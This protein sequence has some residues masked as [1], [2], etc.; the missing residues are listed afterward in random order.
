MSHLVLN[1]RPSQPHAWGD[2]DPSS[3]VTIGGHTASQDFT[4]G[5]RSYRID[6]LQSGDS[7]D[8]V[9]EDVPGDATIN[10]KETLDAAFGGY[11]SFRYT[12]GFRGRNEFDIQSHNVFVRPATGTTPLLYGA[13]LYVVYNPDT[14]AG[15]PLPH[16]TLRWIQ[17][18]KLGGSAVP[19][20]LE[21]PFVDNGRSANPFYT[22]GG[23]TA[24]N[25]N[26]I[27]SVDY[28]VVRPAMLGPGGEVPVLSEQ[29]TAELFLAHD[30]GTRDSTGKEIVHI[31]GG[32]KYGWQLRETQ[33]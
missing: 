4:L 10:F 28:A 17:V 26:R 25:G 1:Y 12:G 7:G 2:P 3:A 18:V 27:F 23:Y 31:F 14:R 22:L 33:A 9:Y 8:P 5:S 32:I 21:S 20:G 6:L 29:F 16:G 11:Y 24:I 19:P 13:D 15:D 30:T